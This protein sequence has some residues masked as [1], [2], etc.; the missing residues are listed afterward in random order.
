MARFARRPRAT[1]TTIRNFFKRGRILGS[2]FAP[3]SLKLTLMG[4]GRRGGVL[5][6]QEKLRRKI[7]KQLRGVKRKSTKL[8]GT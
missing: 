7:P 2:R 4:M 6:R 8:L 5:L 3:G 1:N